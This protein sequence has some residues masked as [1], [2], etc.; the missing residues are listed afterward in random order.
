VVIQLGKIP[1]SVWIPAI[2]HSHEFL[3]PANMSVK[4]VIILM[5]KIII[6]EY[7]ISDDLSD[8]SLLDQSDGKALNFDCS[9]QQLGIANGAKLILV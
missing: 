7:G 3:I 4:D 1:V 5:A 2:S 6:S 8:I 9:F